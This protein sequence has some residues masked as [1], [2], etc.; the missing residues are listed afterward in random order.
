MYIKSLN[1]W[2]LWEGVYKALSVRTEHH[3]QG[4]AAPT[5]HIT[6]PVNCWKDT[7]EFLQGLRWRQ[8]RRASAP[9]QTQIRA[10]YLKGQESCV[11]RHK[12]I[13]MSAS[14]YELSILWLW[15]QPGRALLGGN[16]V[17]H[18]LCQFLHGQ[19]TSLSAQEH[20]DDEEVLNID[21][22]R[23]STVSRSG[24]EM[25]GVWLV[26]DYDALRINRMSIVLAMST[27]LL[28]NRTDFST[29]KK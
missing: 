14:S 29:I 10:K 17:D 7:V 24:R 26:P 15:W 18:C 12:K 4:T 1:D 6:R 8:R 13:W 5:L 20:G 11:K 2:C 21:R 27:W 3:L 19:S 23:D 22:S 25:M 9:P 28:I 16:T